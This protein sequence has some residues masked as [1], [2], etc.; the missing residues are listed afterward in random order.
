M[1]L[2]TDEYKRYSRH[3]SLPGFGLDGQRKLKTASIL[4]IGCG[5]LASSVIMYLAASGIGCIGIVD[6][7][8]VDES[9][10][11]RQLL[12]NTEDIGQK[13]ILVATKRINKLNPNVQVNTYDTKLNE[14]NALDIIKYFDIIIDCTDNFYAKYLINDA[15]FE[16]KKPFIY[17]SIFQFEGQISFFDGKT[18]PCFRC[19]FASP[20]S[21][22]LVSNCTEEGVIGVLPGMVGT[23]QALE[24]I[25]HI[26]GIGNN[27]LGKLLFFDTLHIRTLTLEFAKSEKCPI[28]ID[29]K[30][31]HELTRPCIEECL[32]SFIPQPI[33]PQTLNRTLENVRLIDVR[34]KY[35]HQICNIGGTLIPFN[36][37]KQAIK[38]INKDKSIVIYCKSGKRS[39]EAAK[40]LLEAG[41]NNVFFL[42][43]GILAWIDQINPAM[44][45]Y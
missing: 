6:N 17:G 7:D 39:Q 16:Q 24:A 28:C 41:F 36:S 13:K 34:E 19:L 9:N 31:F 20:P 18:S 4:C 8:I 1:I 5:G 42:E 14:S 29:K 44:L 25:K 30:R 35:E 11:H 3:F 2:S 33:S 37:F 10:L 26:V 43:G 22:N 38:N 45:R 15:C 32:S 12:F 23:L 21:S 40:L 27:L